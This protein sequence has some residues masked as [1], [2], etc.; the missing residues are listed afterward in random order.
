MLAA[1]SVAPLSTLHTF[2]A[3]AAATCSPIRHM[4]IATQLSAGG[5]GDICRER[6][7]SGPRAVSAAPRRVSASLTSGPVLA[8][9]ASARSFA[10]RSADDGRPKLPKDMLHV[11]GIGKSYAKV[12]RDMHGIKTV[13]QLSERIIETLQA[14]DGKVSGAPAVKLLQVGPEQLSSQSQCTCLCVAATRPLCGSLHGS[15]LLSEIYLG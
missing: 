8:A 15:D 9:A 14:T 5:F 11:N 12:L 4:C 2:A 7:N 10:T 1:V 3:A 13:Q 6:M